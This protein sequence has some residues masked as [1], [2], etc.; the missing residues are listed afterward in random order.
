[1]RDRLKDFNWHIHG[2]SEGDI[3]H[4]YEMV[5]KTIEDRNK[6]LDEYKA[7]VEIEDPEM[8]PDILDDICYYHGL[9]NLILWQFA[10]WRLQGIFEGLMIL[11]YLKDPSLSKKL[12]GLKAK[13][14]KMKDS[15]YTLS[16]DDYDTLLEWGELRNALS[17]CPPEWYGY[18]DLFEADIQ[19][20]I[21][22]IKK[23]IS[24]WESEEANH[25]H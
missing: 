19:E 23:V 20:Y 16:S 3:D 6:I 10:L 11:K 22:L 12:I 24:T 1:M 13:L 18:V 15:G 7:R 2:L 21:S 17:H 14:K 4:I 8:A 5:K 9:Q 25:K